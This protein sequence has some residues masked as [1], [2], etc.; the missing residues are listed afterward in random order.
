LSLSEDKMTL[1][2]LV[3]KIIA[4]R[5]NAT[6]TEILHELRVKDNASASIKTIRFDY[7]PRARKELGIKLIRKKPPRRFFRKDEIS[8]PCMSPEDC[9]YVRF[10]LENY[11]L[12]RRDISEEE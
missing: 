10:I 2:E 11:I 5:P 6:S 9:P 12:I 3:R 8:S 4:E 7:A 1:Y